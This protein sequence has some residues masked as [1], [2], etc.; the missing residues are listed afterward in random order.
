[1]PAAMSLFALD[2]RKYGFL[3]R[4]TQAT[5]MHGCW[6]VRTHGHGNTM[7]GGH[8]GGHAV[9]V[10]HTTTHTQASKLDELSPSC[11]WDLNT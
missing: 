2:E 3:R 9:R 7:E 1:M 4:S 10:L 5:I 8:V 6:V 11:S